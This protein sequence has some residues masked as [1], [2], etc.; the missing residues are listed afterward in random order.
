MSTDQRK[1]ELEEKRAKLEKMRQEKMLKNTPTTPMT[2]GF[3]S[4]PAM[5]L[6]TTRE[7]A[8]PD[9]ILKEV[10]ILQT[11]SL[12]ATS[13][14]V[15][16]GSAGGAS[17]SAS[18]SQQ[19][20]RPPSSIALQIC[21]QPTATISV[22]PKE[23]V[24]YS[25]EVQT[26]ESGDKD[27]AASPIQHE[28]LQWDDEFPQPTAGERNQLVYVSD[29]DTMSFDENTK[30]SIGM[31]LASVAKL[32]RT[33]SLKQQNKQFSLQGQSS[34]VKQ[35]LTNEER[36]Q[37]Q[38]SEQFQDFFSR[39]ARI[40]ERSL[41]ESPQAFDLFKDYSGRES[42]EQNEKMDVGEIIKFDREFFDERW[43]RHRI[44]TCIDT[45]TY[46][47]ELV[48]ASYSQ[49]D[50]STHESDGVVLIWNTKFKSKPTPE[51]VFNC[52]SWVT[53]CVFSKFHPNIL[54]GGTYSG[55][56]VV[57]DTRTNKRTPVQRTALSASSHTHPVYCLQ[58]I[59]TQNANNLI[60]ISNE[61]K[62]SYRT[63]PVAATRMVF[64]GVEV[65]N[66]VIGSEEGQA[67]SGS[68]HGNKAGIQDSYEG[69]F[70]PITGLSCHNVNGSVDFSSLFLTSSFDWSVK[71]WSLKESKPLNSFEVNSDYVTDVR[72]SPVHPS[73][74]LTCDITGRF[75][76]WNLNHDS[77]LPLL[78]TTL[79]G[80][81]ALNKC[82]WSHNGQQIILGDDQGKLRLYD[83]NEF[84]TNPKQDDFNKLSSTLQEFKRNT[85]DA[86]DDN[87]P[88]SVPTT[89]TAATTSAT[90]VSHNS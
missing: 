9:K 60:S 15:S 19:K 3:A 70:G 53:S 22:P 71:L 59:G 10:G 48:L 4:I 58:V 18:S 30:P 36:E 81:V 44:V 47:P 16:P 89:T 66:F 45:S 2:P 20:R 41:W 79:D 67:Y 55:Q 82:L 64:P 49:N 12:P 33:R 32:E 31:S 80:N 37:I 90:S 52:Q 7:D 61:G 84:L 63:K 54:L 28:H 11:A 1:R 6:T 72:W 57:W 65:N 23:L 14:S 35:E 83:V 68:R 39:S 77:E 62:M 8:D 69:H 29:E 86:F 75:D 5:T 50:E 26:I 46:H 78:S 21:Q 56:I 34:L 38:K 76:I 25:K 88:T 87:H 42:D 43:T 74:F 17:A 85:L 24:T 27:P 73:V 40:I 13:P 51:Y